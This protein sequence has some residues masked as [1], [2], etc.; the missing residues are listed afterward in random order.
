MKDADKTRL[1]AVTAA[2][3]T[4]R[5]WMKEVVLRAQNALVLRGAEYFWHFR[6]RR[7]TRSLALYL[8]ARARCA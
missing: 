3:A 4:A 6:R 1:A 7:H 8:F 2:P 5:R